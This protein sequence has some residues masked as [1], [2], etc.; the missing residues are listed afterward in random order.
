MYV[1]IPI[2]EPKFTCGYRIGYILRDGHRHRCYPSRARPAAAAAIA[3]AAAT[4]GAVA[5]VA[6][7]VVIG[8]VVV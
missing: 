3:V 7:G 8:G 6:D 2:E 4:A 1:G 5:D